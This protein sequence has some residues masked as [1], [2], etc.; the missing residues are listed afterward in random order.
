MYYVIVFPLAWNNYVWEAP[1]VKMFPYEAMILP[2]I[3]YIKKHEA[4][5]FDANWE[6][7]VQTPIT[8]YIYVGKRVPDAPQNVL[9]KIGYRVIIEKILNRDQLISQIQ[10]EYKYVPFW[11]QQC[12]RW[13]MA[14]RLSLC[15]TKT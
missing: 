12:P 4:I 11:R 1:D 8:G 13:Q 10:R 15:R 14:F 9:G 5:Y 6:I 2:H 7:D 3:Q